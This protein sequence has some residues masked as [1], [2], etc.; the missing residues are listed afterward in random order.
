MKIVRCEFQGHFIIPIKD[1]D[2]PDEIEVALEHYIT[3]LEQQ[4][5]PMAVLDEYDW[6]V[7]NV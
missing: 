5:D 6:S 4:M 1:D 2:G 3:A 7:K